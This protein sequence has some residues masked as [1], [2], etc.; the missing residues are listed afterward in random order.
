TVGTQD[1]SQLGDVNVQR[2]RGR[3]GR[4]VLPQR[5]D[6]RVRRDDPVGVQEQDRKEGALLRARDLDRALAIPQLEPS[7]NAVSH[8]PSHTTLRHRRS[9]YKAVPYRRVTAP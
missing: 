5:L 2:L 8:A 3:L 4:V 6:Q 7:Q 9:A 1:L